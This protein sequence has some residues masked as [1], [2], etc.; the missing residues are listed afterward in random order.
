MTAAL[1]HVLDWPGRPEN[2]TA[3]QHYPREPWP[4]ICYHV[5]NHALYL[6]DRLLEVTCKYI[7]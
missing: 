1:I 4:E 5:L 6:N 3:V 7:K 2:P